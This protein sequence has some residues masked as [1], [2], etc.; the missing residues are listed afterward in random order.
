MK[1]Q[2]V[3]DLVFRVFGILADGGYAEDDMVD[4]Q[5]SQDAVIITEGADGSTT[6][7]YVQNKTWF[8][9]FRCMENSD[10]H[11][12]M[13]GVYAQ[14]Q[15]GIQVSGSG[16]FRRST[17]GETLQSSNVVIQRP[18]NMVAGK[19]PKLREWSFAFCDTLYTNVA[20]G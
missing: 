6:V 10:F 7:S 17:S 3:K 11:R 16:L 4:A 15:A 9:K 1:K 14:Q 2:S 18:P 5:P 13:Q 19:S 8:V 20:P 12:L